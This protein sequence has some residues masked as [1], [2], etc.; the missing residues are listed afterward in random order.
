RHTRSTRDWSSDVCSSDLRVDA[1]Y[2]YGS[3]RVGDQAF[4]ER[5]DR[6]LGDRTFLHVNDQDVVARYP[7]K[8][9][10]Y[11]DLGVPRR[12]FAADGSR[13][14]ERREGKGR[15]DVGARW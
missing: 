9:L 12:V 3:P 2:A 7:P 14:E 5:Y 1:V 10:G 13:S 11:Q 15:G 6:E 8:L 4:V